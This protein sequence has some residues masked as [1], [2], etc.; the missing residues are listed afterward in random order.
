TEDTFDLSQPTFYDIDLV[1][2]YGAGS[3]NP[4]Y[5]VANFDLRWSD[6]AFLPDNVKDAIR[7]NMVTPYARPTEDAAGT[8]LA[9]ILLQNARHSR[10]GPD[11]TQDNGRELVRDVAGLGGSRDSVAFVRNVDWDIG[12]TY[13][14]VEVENRERGTDS[15][16]FAL[17]AD[18]VVD[19]AGLV[20]GT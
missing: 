9:P 10:F 13:G 11:R 1:N 8:P 17:A 15:L 4:I 3:A 16:R 7:N 6:N 12:Y 20:S 14:E 19:T 2:S 5:N 18:A